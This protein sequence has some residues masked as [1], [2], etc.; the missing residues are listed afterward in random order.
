MNEFHLKK[1]MSY[2]CALLVLIGLMLLLFAGGNVQIARSQTFPPYNNGRFGFGFTGTG[3]GPENYNVAMLNAGWYWDWGA[4]A[5]SRIP[6]LEYMRTIRLKPVKSGSTQIG[7]TAS[8]T[9]TTLLNRIA[10]APGATWLIGNE[11]D[12]VNM[13]NMQSQWYARAYH[14]L[15]TTIKRADPTAQVVAGSIVQPTLQRFMYLDRVLATYQQEY[16]EPLPT[17]MWATHSYILCENCYPIKVEGEPF[18]WG[19]CW[20]PDWPSSTSSKPYATFY[21]V[22][23]HWKIDVFAQRMVAMR[24]WMYDNG[25]RNHPLIITEYGILFYNGLV[26]SDAT[27]DAKNQEFMY[28]GFDWMQ[29][30]RDPLL[31]YAPDDNRLVQRWAWFSLDHDDWYMGGALFDYRTHQPTALGTSFGAYTTQ[32]TPTPQLFPLSVSESGDPTSGGESMTATLSAT[33]ANA[34]NISLSSPATATFFNKNNPAEII[35]Q[36]PI[37]GLGCCGD[38]VSVTTFWPNRTGNE[39]NEFC[40]TVSPATEPVTKCDAL[41]VRLKVQETWGTVP[42][43]MHSGEAVTATLYAHVKNVGL[44]VTTDPVTVAFT[45]DYSGTFRRQEAVIPPLGCCGAESVAAV[46]WPDF[47]RDVPFSITLATSYTQT[48]PVSVTI[49]TRLIL[50]DVWA[51]DVYGDTP[52][53]ATLYATIANEGNL[54]TGEPTT[55]SF[56][57]PETIVQ[58]HTI[59]TSDLD[60][61]GASAIVSITWPYAEDGTHEFCVQAATSYT[62]TQPICARFIV[63]P[64]HLYLPVV[65]HEA[66]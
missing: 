21:S 35:A 15:Y 33:I 56:Y 44:M 14:D 63:N 32:V 6:P 52:V 2:G 31:G 49:A 24:Q 55:V 26:Y 28:G 43:Q 40:V 48:E 47:R 30:A 1:H 9:G 59:L 20:V 53:S 37:T 4:T 41:K 16:G 65:V 10:A 29:S 23:D 8:P 62:E 54:N 18:A 7:Y 50:S 13:D 38:Y 25:Y 45:A 60:R 39:A 11:P 12:C 66:P 61:L 57:I 27:Y 46:V 58:P 19:A 36:E 22:Y 51:L 5:A 64:K 34:G 42:Y 17:D 3:G